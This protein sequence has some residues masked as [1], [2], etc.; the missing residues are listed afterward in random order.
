MPS[1]R[2]ICIAPEAIAYRREQ[3][4]VRG[5][6]WK[7][8]AIMDGNAHV[9]YMPDVPVKTREE[10]EELLCKGFG[11][12][13]SDALQNALCLSERLIPPRRTRSGRMSRGAARDSTPGDDTWLVWVTHKD[14][15][16]MLGTAIVS[17]M[18]NNKPVLL[19]ITVE[20]NPYVRGRH[21]LFQVLAFL[22]RKGHSMI[23]SA[24]DDLQTGQAFGGD[25]HCSAKAAHVNWGFHEIEQAEWRRHSPDV[26]YN[27][28]ENR[29]TL[30]KKVLDE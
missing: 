20:P 12:T 29:V 7:K 11:I 25:A 18:D 24:V 15:G 27:R 5:K 26:W 13:R 2:G 19:Y 9:A 14:N 3:K 6:I 4:M 17:M 23:L 30:L 1:S 28:R 22:R 21:V 8:G 16:R 10:A